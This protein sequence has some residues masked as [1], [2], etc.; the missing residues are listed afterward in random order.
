MLKLQKWKHL[1]Y[2]S[3]NG[4]EQSITKPPT[5]QQGKTNFSD[6]VQRRVHCNTAHCT[7]GAVTMHTAQWALCA[8][9]LITLQLLR[10]YMHYSKICLKLH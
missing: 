5:V 1:L 9:V 10:N 7:V 2:I 4:A 3:F 6:F 8:F